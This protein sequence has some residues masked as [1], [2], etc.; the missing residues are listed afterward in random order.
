MFDIEGIFSAAILL[1]LIVCFVHVVVARWVFKDAESRGKPG[2]LAVILVIMCLPLGM[3]I[4]LLL[5]PPKLPD[6]EESMSAK[7][8]SLEQLA[9]SRSP[10]DYLADLERSSGSVSHSNG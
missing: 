7:F 4:W 1:G 8:D 5:R 6:S 9:W 3:V 2:L 10:V